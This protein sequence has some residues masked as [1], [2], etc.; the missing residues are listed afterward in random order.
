MNETISR[1]VRVDPSL[2]DG[3]IMDRGGVTYVRLL[4]KPQPRQA[5]ALKVF[6][7]ALTD[8]TGKRKKERLEV[9]IFYDANIVV[10][11][12]FTLRFGLEYLNVQGGRVE[13]VYDAS[14]RRA[15]VRFAVGSGTLD[16][17]SEV[18]GPDVGKTA[19]YV[20]FLD[21]PP[22]EQR[23]LGISRDG[24]VDLPPAIEA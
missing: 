7:L 8:T 1:S 9:A 23:V 16:V 3:P 17:T 21:A 11:A 4:V 12:T 14:V 20:D 6:E 15:R 22:D 2:L 5:T 10:A 18:R 24:T 13:V 19:E